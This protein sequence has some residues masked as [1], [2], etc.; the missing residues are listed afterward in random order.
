MVRDRATNKFKG[1]G[2]VEFETVEDLAEA[3]NM[4]GQVNDLLLYFTLFNI[5]IIIC[6]AYSRSSDQNR[7]G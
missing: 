4:H 7:C 5:D 6:V 2:Y 1:F 3:M